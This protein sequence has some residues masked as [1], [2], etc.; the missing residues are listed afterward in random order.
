MLAL[1]RDVSPAIQHC[2][3]THLQRVPIDPV[4]AAD[5]H[6]RYEASLVRAGC[7]IERLPTLPELADSV[8]VEDVAVV[9]DEC[10]VVTRPGAPSRRRERDTVA[11][12]LDR[13]RP[14]SFIRP[15]ATL[16]GGDVLIVGRQ[17]FVGLSSR[18]TEDGLAQLRRILGAHGYEVRSVRVDGCLHLKSAVTA[19]ADETLLI[20]RAWV[21]ADAFRDFTLLDVDPAEPA[22]ANAL[23]VGASVIYPAAFPR[24]R[25]RLEGHGLQVSPVDVSELA[26]AEGAVTCCSLLLT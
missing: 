19:V 10:A 22:G 20:N 23:R 18:T 21:A 4:R 17:V 2:E 11:V 16:D 25:A 7:A 5:Q 15:P 13:Y 8:F 12:A 14:V 6:R 1:T 3:L 26:K 24:T 9:V